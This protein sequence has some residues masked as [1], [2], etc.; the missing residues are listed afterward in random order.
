ML[1]AITNNWPL[2]LLAVILAVVLSVYVYQ[3]G[4]YE[5]KASLDMPLEVRNLSDELAFL[6]VPPAKIKINISGNMQQVNSLKREAIRA[7]IDL[8]SFSAPGSYTISPE[9]PDTPLLKIY[10]PVP[11]LRIRLAKKM[12]NRLSV[13]IWHRGDLPAGYLLSRESIAPRQVDVVGP[14]EMVLSARRVIAEVAL[15]GRLSRI[16]QS[17][18]LVAYTKDDVPLDPAIVR[19][20]PGSAQYSAEVNPVANVKAVRINAELQGSPPAGYYLKEMRITPS[21]ILFSETLYAQHPLKTLSVEPVSLEGKK[22]SFT[23][24]AKILYGFT[25]PPDL[26][27]TVTIEVTLGKLAVSEDTMLTI[28]VDLV[29]RSPEYDYLVNPTSVILQSADFVGFTQTD[30]SEV[31]VVAN[32]EGLVP[33]IHRISPQVNLPPSIR[34]IAVIPESIEV[35]VIQR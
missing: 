3:Y 17:I 10:G 23:Q 14:E 15:A 4:E 31:K 11:T 16:S 18:P 2:K 12:R 19:I 27:Q 32:V 21:Q 29:G 13:E 35:S 30:R 5:M 22:G 25:A 20:E 28:S 8:K 7:V 34:D 1:K 24:S 26:P 6:E 33:G 9:L